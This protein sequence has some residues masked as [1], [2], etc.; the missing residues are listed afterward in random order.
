MDEEIIVFDTET[1][2]DEVQKLLF[3]AFRY[4]LRHR[5]RIH[6]LAEGLIYADDLPETNAEG[7]AQLVRYARTHYKAANVNLNSFGPREP[8]WRLHLMSR[9]EFVERWIWKIAYLRQG[10]IV[11]FNLPFDL[12]RI[13]IDVTDARGSFTEGY[14]FQLWKYGMRPNL[15][16]KH[17]DSKRAFIGWALSNIPDAPKFRGKFIDLRT[18]VFALTASGHSLDSAAALFG[19][20]TRKAVPAEH[21]VITA[22]YIDYCRTD[23]ATTSELYERV[24]A[25]YARH[26]IN[27]PLQDLYSPATLAKGY[28]TA[29]G[30]SPPMEKYDVDENVIGAVASTFY[31]GR[32][33][34][35]IRHVDT[36]VM[37]FDFTS[38]YPTV[39]ALMGLWQHVTAAEMT[40]VDATDDVRQLVAEITLDR[41]FDPAVWRNFVGVVKVL[42]DMDIFPVRARYG[43][44]AS[45]NIGV[46]FLT[47]PETLWYSI[48]D[49]IA[50]TLLTGKAPLIQKAVRFE[51]A[52]VEKLRP[53][54]LRGDIIIDPEGADF[55]TW[56][57]E[58]RA[59]VKTSNP[60]LADFLKMLAN[61][62]SY[63]IFAETIQ[64]ESLG[65]RT[66]EVASAPDDPWKVRVRHPERPGRF[67][68][69]PIA[70]CITGAARLMLAM[71]EQLVTDAGGSWVFCDTDS[72]AITV[73]GTDM[74]GLPRDT[75]V[76]LA[77]RFDALNPYAPE[78]IPHL[79]KLEFEGWCRSISSK[80]YALWNDQ[81]IVKSSE[82]GLGHL[83]GPHRGW[84]R[85]LWSHI[86][87]HTPE[88][89]WLDMPAQ[90]QWT[91]STPRLYKTLDV[92]NSGLPYRDRIKPFNFLSA[93]YVRREHKPRL[94]QGIRGFQLVTGYLGDKE[95]AEAEWLNKY[96][97]G[98]PLYRI[99]NEFQLFDD[100]VRVVTYRDV[101][102][103][104]IAHPESKFEDEN[105]KSGPHS[106]GL[107]H[108]RHVHGAG[109]DYIGKEGN[110]LREIQLGLIDLDEAQYRNATSN[111]IWDQV[112]D[113]VFR[114]LARNLDKAN[115][116]YVGITKDAYSR[117][118]RGIARPHPRH[119]DRF[120][121]LAVELA[122]EDLGRSPK[123]IKDRRTLFAEWHVRKHNPDTSKPPEN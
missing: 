76:Q 99:T 30:I 110:K 109:A 44:G 106:K 52:G 50:S 78:V 119:R 65:E 87:G 84:K 72:M 83:R 101:L 68:W 11:G 2:T 24:T 8:D 73:A 105:G 115:A 6:W 23:V 96:D 48:P 80:R 17:L 46:N 74:P 111:Q 51:P 98:G 122:C 14:S 10:L 40:V 32:T 3:G 70:T 20:Q 43:G 75:I 121:A 13:A 37:L 45:S 59:R 100:R 67:A 19:C 35:R 94:R 120:L 26:S 5:G 63:G 16:V 25:E 61:A 62:G 33:E 56:V 15:R 36:P 95:P 42:P 88:P 47:Y 54:S 4:G 60:P 55:F 92:W 85:E 82:H 77:R 64:D 97:P 79:L 107:L 27:K 39:N 34:T 22:D 102:N 123:L 31:G 69:P 1:T 112:R 104:Y 58:Q 41:C 9:S 108:R 117:I 28:Y 12:S 116:E 89:V 103:E 81:G 93:V 38:M 29:M 66:V 18:A 71:L 86:I 118:K 53:V 57:I 7:Y 49:V 21:G 90:S 113:N 91:V 114:I